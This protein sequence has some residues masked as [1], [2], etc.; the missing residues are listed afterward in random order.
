MGHI[1]AFDRVLEAYELQLGIV[2]PSAQGEEVQKQFH[3]LVGSEVPAGWDHQLRDEVG[4][5][6]TYGQTRL[7]FD[8]DVT[9]S[10]RAQWFSGWAASLGNIQTS[11]QLSGGV[12]WGNFSS[13]DYG[14]PLI[15]SFTPGSGY[16]TLVKPVEW[17]TY[18]HLAGRYVAHEIFLDGNTLH[19][20]PEVDREPWLGEAQIGAVV[21]WSAYRVSY[22]HVLPTREFESQ[23][24][25]DDYGAVTVSLRF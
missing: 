7:V 21:S 11:A 20:G 1:Q 22:T 25:T 15:R 16:Y 6:V 17:Y 14:P 2:G 23:R 19:E 13:Q 4:V 9:R 5:R 8:H 24:R 12:R 10:T 3:K 18:L